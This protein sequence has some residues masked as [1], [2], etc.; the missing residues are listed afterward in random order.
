M[1]H[2]ES[3]GGLIEEE[4]LIPAANDEDYETDAQVLRKTKKI[5]LMDVQDVYR[6]VVDNQKKTERSTRNFKF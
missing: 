2:S 5:C 3:Q 6:S 1:F 4:N